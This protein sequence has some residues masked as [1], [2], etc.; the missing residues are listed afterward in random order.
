MAP[1]ERTA[2]DAPARTART[3]F[4]LV[5]LLTASLAGGIS[6]GAG[7]ATATTAADGRLDPA[8]VYASP[9]G[10]VHVLGE[11][12]STTSFGVSATVVGPMADLDGD[13]RLDVPYVTSGG[14]VAIVGLDGSTRTLVQGTAKASKTKLGVGDWDGDGTPAVLYVGGDGSTVNRVEVGGSA[15]TV[16]DTG[17]KAALGVTDFDA[18][19]DRD[20]VFVGSSSGIK[21]YDGAVHTTGYSSIGSNNGLGVGAPA[22][23]DGDGTPRV[24][25]VDGSNNLALVGASGEK[26]VLTPNYGAAAK[27]PV[28]AGDVVGDARL[29][30]VHVNKDG[31]LAYATLGGSTGVLSA[32]GS[33]IAA[34]GAVGAAAGAEPPAPAISNFSLQN[35]EGR[36]LSVSF[37]SSEQLA[38]VEVTVDGPA[39]RTL[40]ESDFSVEG[41]GPYTYTAS[42]TVD[43]DGS[44]T[45]T[46]RTAADAGGNDGAD[47]QT[48]STTVETPAPTVSDATL[49]AADGD[50]VVGVGDEIRVTAVVTGSQNVSVTAD[51][52]RFGAGRVT[53]EP[54][55]DNVYAAT[56][57]VGRDAGNSGTY[58]VEV[59]ASNRYGNTDTDASDRLTLD[60]QKPSAAVG[61]NRTVTVGS[62][63][64]FD[65]EASTDNTRLVRY[66][67]SFGDGAVTT[68]ATATHTYST[69]GNY[70]VSLRVTDAAGNVDAATR[71]ITVVQSDDGHGVPASD[72]NVTLTRPDPGVV[73]A[74]VTDVAAGR[75]VAIDLPATETTDAT[76]AYISEIGLTPT[77]SGSFTLTAQ[78]SASVPDGVAPLAANHSTQALVYYDLSHTIAE[79]NVSAAT[80]RVSVSKSQVV[81]DISEVALYRHHDGAWQKLDTR[82]VNETEDRYVL[83]ASA[84]GLSYYAVGAPQPNFTVTSAT[85]EDPDQQVRTGTPFNVTATVHN[86]G[87]ASGTFH[88]TLSVANDSVATKNVTVPAGES[89]TITFT[90]RVEESGTYRVAVEGTNAG[91]I[92]V[93]ALGGLTMKVI[94]LVVALVGIAL[95]AFCAWY[96]LRR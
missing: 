33:S 86:S 73:V 16:V 14:D 52:S 12:G 3:L 41:T 46:L 17:A 83:G 49:A 56:A 44:Y 40:T 65:A 51:L 27:G 42:L 95:V 85:I 21:F 58:R 68:G 1:S 71:R 25:V 35:P 24:P 6:V 54:T 13:G 29:E 60:R 64:G 50:D 76:G 89:R 38:N 10:T 43:A 70:T 48:A 94:R 37:E 4:L 79:E 31:N 28:G 62:V 61:P 93:R 36:Q 23:F 57:T 53:L 88:A 81:A 45:A 82:L 67:W 5:T 74:D 69:P 15:H 92:E 34:S 66:H 26:T 2:I 55:G 91:T 96:L 11:D 77:R 20:L 9:D 18:D 30:A 7:A 75:V 8:A 47:G 90:H 78:T 22:D 80:F 72:A 84:A 59:R 32:D 19:G 87:S 39:S 63:V